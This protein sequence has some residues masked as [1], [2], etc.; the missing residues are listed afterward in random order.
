LKLHIANYEPGRTGGGW[1][2]SRYLANKLGQSDYESADVYMI[3]GASM[4]NST[5]FNNGVVEKAKSDG[6]K[7]VLRIDNALRN[8]RNGNLGMT[9]MKKFAELADVVI[10]QSKWA[11]DYLMPFTKKDGPVI[12]NGCDLNLFYPDEKRPNTYIYSRVNRDE[13]KGWEVARYWFSRQHITGGELDALKSK[14]YIVG[15][16]S[17]ELRDANFDFYMGENY[18]F[19]A[20][21][22]TP[23]YAKLLRQSESFIYTYFMDACSNSACEALVS[24]CR[25]VGPKYFQTTG[26]MPEILQAFREGGREALGLER[27]V[28]EYKHHLSM[29]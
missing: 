7:I 23:A 24:G 2:F 19:L 15:N 16:F 17:P 28:G 5:D 8:S 26:G 13:T 4:I 21:L 6:K 22:A 10:Y 25:I 1:T 11:K 12:L 14:L 3:T 9:R 27:M 20:V 29:L 18:E